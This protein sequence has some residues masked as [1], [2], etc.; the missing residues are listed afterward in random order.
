MSTL[1]VI[2]LV[3]LACIFC[4]ISVMTWESVSNASSAPHR[5]WTDYV[6]ALERRLYSL[7]LPRVGRTIALAQATALVLT[8]A[9]SVISANPVWLALSLLAG[10]GPML[11]LEYMRRKRLVLLEERLDT[12]VLALSN[13]LKTT[14]SVASALANTEPVTPAPLDQEV[15]LAL[16]ELRLGNTLEQALLN[17]SARVKSPALD[18]TLM[19]VLIGRQVGGNL[20]EILNTTA[21]TLR[22][23]ARLQGVVRSKT[24]ESKAQLMVLAVFPAIIIVAFDLVRPGYF[25]PLTKDIIGWCVIASAG[26][27]WVGALVTA[28]KV[29]AV[30]V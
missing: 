23:M 14:P 11:Y 13:S 9:F 4:A 10:P 16:K 28:R 17:M 30:D 7:F 25:E 1:E 26:L 2:R 19:G 8:V 27:L 21:E 24:A 22:E 3:V 20:P 5:A 29:L 12:F 6:S 18:A 15:G